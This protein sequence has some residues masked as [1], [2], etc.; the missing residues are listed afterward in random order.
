MLDNNHASL[1]ILTPIPGLT[2]KNDEKLKQRL[3]EYKA[4]LSKEEIDRI[5]EETKALKIYQEEPSSKE[6]MEK[7][8]R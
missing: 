6:D 3:A 5:I 7:I 8:G 1:V 4:S 2:S